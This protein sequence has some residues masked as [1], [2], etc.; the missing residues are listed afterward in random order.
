[1]I[2]T[3]KIVITQTLDLTDMEDA[4]LPLNIVKPTVRQLQVIWDTLPVSIQKSAIHWGLT[5]TNVRD[6]IFLF[7]QTN[8]PKVMPDLSEE[9]G[10]AHV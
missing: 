7:L 3:S 10:R 2:M 5:D 1:M 9:I 4:L 8:P 6:E